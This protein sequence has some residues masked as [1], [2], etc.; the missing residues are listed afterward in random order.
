MI[1]ILPYPYTRY[2][3]DI[4]G[5]VRDEQTYIYVPWHLGPNSYYYC[6]NLYPEGSTQ[7]ISIFVHRL[8]AICFL[9][10]P[11]PD[12]YTFDQL[13]VN[14]ID[15]NKLNN[16]LN[17][18]EWVTHQQNC[19]HAYRTGLRKDNKPVILTNK[20]S[21]ECVVCYSQAE[22]ARTVKRDPATICE[23]LRNKGYF[24]TEEWFGQRQK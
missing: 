4:F 17:N 8:L 18:L 6:V 19:Q 15:G 3:I 21:G 2:T 7:S 13:Q 5:Y 14:H 24:E 12:Q 16:D 1:S 23:H 11:F 9:P 10:N 20:L 22:A